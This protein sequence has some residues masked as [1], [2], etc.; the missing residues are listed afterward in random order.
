MFERITKNINQFDNTMRVAHEKY[1]KA[2]EELPKSYRGELLKEKLEQA[3]KEFNN[4]KTNEIEDFKKIVNEEI[5]KYFNEVNDIITK[6]V[7]S[8]FLSTLEALKLGKNDISNYEAEAYLNKYKNNYTSCKAILSLLHSVNKGNDLAIV[9]AEA[10]KQELSDLKESL[11]Q[12][13][14]NYNI[15]SLATSFYLDEK[16]SPVAISIQ[17]IEPFF[18]Q[19]YFMFN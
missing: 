16:T 8:D 11:M 12:F 13:A 17:K 14:Y 4:I 6:P 3:T 15:D 1:K 2:Q 9:N 7:E 18:N 10:I 19:D 5:E